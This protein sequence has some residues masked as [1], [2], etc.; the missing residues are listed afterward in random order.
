MIIL[1]KTMIIMKFK[2]V[3]SENLKIIATIKQTENSAERVK[4]LATGDT[5]IIYGYGGK[6]KYT[7]F[8]NP[9]D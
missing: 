4:V 7:S 6:H 5:T 1:M 2:D 8:S 9:K 3:A